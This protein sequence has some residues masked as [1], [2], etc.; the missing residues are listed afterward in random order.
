MSLK[1]TPEML[2]GA[3][4]FLRTTEPFKGWKLP[5]SDDVGFHVISTPNY[6]ADSICDDT[7]GE[8][9]IT[10]RVSAAK[11]GHTATLLANI[12]HEMVHVRQF[13][14]GDSGNHNA[15]FK[16]CAARICRAHGFDPLTF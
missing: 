11:N 1:L 14:T 9:K 10:I 16:R 7:S 15:L 4:D 12:A 13:L 8:L 2:A 3:Y 6:H 5:E